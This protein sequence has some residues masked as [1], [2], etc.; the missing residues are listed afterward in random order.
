MIGVDERR[1]RAV[2]PVYALAGL[3]ILAILVTVVI[4]LFVF[5]IV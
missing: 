5:G 2:S 1:D 3:A 4:G